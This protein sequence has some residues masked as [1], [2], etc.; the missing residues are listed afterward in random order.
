MNGVHYFD[1]IFSADDDR[2]W[3]GRLALRRTARGLALSE[4]AGRNTRSWSLVRCPR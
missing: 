1:V 2:Q 3:P 4:I